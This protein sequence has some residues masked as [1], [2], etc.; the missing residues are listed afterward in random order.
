MEE[1]ITD[2]LTQKGLTKVEFCK[3]YG[4]SK[5]HFKEIAACTWLNKLDKIAEALDMEPLKLLTLYYKSK[6]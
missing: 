3:R 2:L 1:F 4:T 6:K 5:Q